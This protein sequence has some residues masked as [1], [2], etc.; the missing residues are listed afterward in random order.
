M[1]FV[2][3]AFLTELYN[4]NR[5]FVT[6]DLQNSGFDVALRLFGLEII[7]HFALEIFL[8][9]DKAM[10]DRFGVGICVLVFVEIL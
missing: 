1:R 3:L 6:F 2:S 4:K 7:A 5:H 9:G 8:G 10:G